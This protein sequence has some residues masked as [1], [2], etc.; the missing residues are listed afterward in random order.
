MEELKGNAET[1]RRVKGMHDVLPDEQVGWERVRKVTCE[2][3]TFYNFT[4]MD[5][6]LVEP[7]ELFE[8]TIGSATDIVEKQM[9]VVKGRG[10]E[11][12]VLRPEMTASFARAFIE[13]GMSQL[14]LPLRLYAIGPVFRYEQ[15]QA[16]RYRQFN[17]VDF[18]ILSTEDDPIYDAQSLL[19]SFR[20]LEHLK[21]REI[22]IAINS[23][24]CAACREPYKRALVAHYKPHKPKLCQDCVRR[25]ETNPLRLLDCKDER[26]QEFKRDAP[27]LLDALCATC[28]RHFKRVLEYLDVLNIPYRLN[29]YLVRGL[30]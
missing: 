2:I 13:N 24:G 1:P 17:Q 12:L 16:G 26:C 5:M 28:K 6:P 22:C 20:F 25:L 29:N 30:D 23:I 11:Q 14:G 27:I 8:R 18:E 19:T 3:A 9:F 15:P 7:A 4:R 21:L 10:R